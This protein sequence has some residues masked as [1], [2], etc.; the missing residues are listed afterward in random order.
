[1]AR[2]LAGDQWITI[3]IPRGASASFNQRVWGKGHYQTGKRSA[4]T[5]KAGL[6][7]NVE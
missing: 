4:A 6:L 3:S 1:M 2:I 7:E 5:P